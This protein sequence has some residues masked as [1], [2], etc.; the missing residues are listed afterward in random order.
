[1]HS[2]T[3]GSCSAPLRLA[4]L[5]LLSF[6]FASTARAQI[7]PGELAAPHASLEGLSKCTSCHTLGKAVSNQNCLACHTELSKRINAGT[8]LHSKYSQRQCT[9][10]HKEH[11]GRDFSLVR[12]DSKT[13]DHNTT[14]FTLE[15]KHGSVACKKCHT[16]EYIKAADIAANASLI[17][18]GTYLGLAREC[19]SCHADVHRGQFSQDCLQCHAM[20]GWKPAQKFNHE[21]ARYPLT[22]KHIQVPCS[23]CHA[24]MAGSG[25][26]VKY[27]G[28][29]FSTCSF[30]HRD[31]HAGKFT[32]PCESCHTTSGWAQGSARN[33]D[34]AQTRFPLSGKHSS[35]KC[36][37]CH[38]ATKGAPTKGALMPNRF[39]IV[40]FSLCDDCHKDPHLGQ[41]TRRNATPT[42]ASCHVESGWKDSKNAPFD[43]ATTKFP[44]K[45]KHSSVQCA[46][47][48]GREDS[49]KVTES[50]G[51]VD[52]TKFGK[53]SECHK[54]Y[55]ESQFVSRADKGACETCHT[56][57]SF[58][59]STFSPAM[60]AETRFSLVG[61]HVA[62]PCIKCHT[63]KVANDP[64]S[65]VYVRTGAIRC[66]DCH[67][68]QHRDEFTRVKTTDC[69]SCHST[70]SWKGLIFDHNKT[71]FKL[72]GK[73]IGV[74]CAECHKP[75]GAPAGSK[76]W[77]FQDIPARCVDCH[78]GSIKP[79][80]L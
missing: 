45:G 71:K 59:P 6:V 19:L 32:K 65:V 39:H 13:F 22:G 48:H 55:H 40:K 26:P 18:E 3:R 21:R 15:G 47:C 61:A 11:H 73:H 8:G 17:I 34:H 29:D 46:R 28:I 60:H 64:S 5:A 50:A 2:A 20:S 79:E 58:S 14:G 4:V 1:L 10:C 67:K 38:A 25:S 30:C 70:D 74:P 16:R 77:R 56:E 80:N 12:F 42:C 49:I 24:P 66:L 44:L 76:R 27:K 33:F 75:K 51:R 63:R 68:D 54:E 52:I 36:E 57:T 53:C 7:S 78:A 23:K 35:L 37:Q 69:E 62:I 31:P 9:E 72:T 43:H 41:F